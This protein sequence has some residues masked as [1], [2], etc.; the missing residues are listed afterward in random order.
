M[1]DFI[2]LSDSKFDEFLL[3]KQN[4][5]ENI[6]SIYKLKKIKKNLNNVLFLIKCLFE[7]IMKH[8]FF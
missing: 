7:V 8:I 1:N 3:F 5:N 4:I 2:F 6:Y